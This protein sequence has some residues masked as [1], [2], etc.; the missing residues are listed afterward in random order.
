MGWSRSS[1]STFRAEDA[2][3]RS[4]GD[5]V[6]ELAAA[7]VDVGDVDSGAPGDVFDRELHRRL[8][9]RSMMA[10][11]AAIDRPGSRASGRGIFAIGNSSRIRPANDW[12]TSRSDGH[13]WNIESAGQ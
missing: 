10:E 7:A 13:R 6:A 9:L 4:R 8:L 3:P 5:R 2:R 11:G 1:G 12:E